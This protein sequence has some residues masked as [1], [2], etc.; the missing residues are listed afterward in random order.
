MAIKNWLGAL[1]DKSL[2]ISLPG[3]RRVHGVEIKK[4][5]TRKYLEAM[6]KLEEMPM[7]MLEDLFPG[8]SVQDVFRSF[9]SADKNS[10]APL[11]AKVLTVA[12]EYVITVLCEI[13]GLDVGRAMDELTPMEL[14]E[15]FMA[16]WRVNDLSDFFEIARVGIKKFLPALQNTGSSDGSPLPK[17]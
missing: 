12:P 10:I 14:A 13:T 2:G 1:G 6:K 9:A 8:Q 3:T 17:A 11:L 4:T 15:V 5:P 16:W 7:Q